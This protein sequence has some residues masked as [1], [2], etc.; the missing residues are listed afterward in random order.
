VY[1]LPFGRGKA[2]LNNNALVDGIIGGWQISGT[3]VISSGN[4]FNVQGTQNTY[5]QAGQAYPDW[6]PGAGWKPSN[7]SIKNWFNPGAFTQPANGTF[8]DV[9]RNSLYGPGLDVVNLSGGKTFSIW[10][11][12]KLQIRA[13]AQNAFN[14]PSFGVPAD[15][16]LGGSNGPGTPYTTGTTVINTVT[17]NGRN[18][19][20]GA[21]LTF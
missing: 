2:Y 19:Q 4:P 7:Q 13:D 18:V 9:R 17:V 16:S 10:E 6:T 15:A 12:V 5:Q 11:N 3:V 20:L 8:G 1:E 14:H 21:R